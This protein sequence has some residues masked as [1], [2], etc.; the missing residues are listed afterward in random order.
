[1]LP[2]PWLSTAI[3]ATATASHTTVF[4]LLLLCVQLYRLRHL[5][6]LRLRVR[7]QF[8]LSWSDAL[9]AIEGVERLPVSES[10]HAANILHRHSTIP[11]VLEYLHSLGHAV[12]VYERGVVH[13]ESDIEHSRHISSVSTDVISQTLC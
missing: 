13:A 4:P 1:M 7:R 8:I 3:V 5:P 10:H 9:E 2:E 6:L 12:A 11:V